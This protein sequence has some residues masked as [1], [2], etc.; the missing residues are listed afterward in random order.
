MELEITIALHWQESH[1]QLFQHQA[2]NRNIYCKMRFALE[3]D[4][5]T[6]GFQG[7]ALKFKLTLERCLLHASVTV[8]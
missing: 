4:S 7:Q 1:S 5:E 8:F 3:S 2:V 6:P